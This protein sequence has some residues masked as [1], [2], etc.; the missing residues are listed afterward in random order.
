LQY[1]LLF[2]S[3]FVKS[4]CAELFTYFAKYLYLENLN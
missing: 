2:N 4:S 3:S 1:Q